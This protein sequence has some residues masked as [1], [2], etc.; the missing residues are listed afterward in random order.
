[1][2]A[3][4]DTLIPVLEPGDLVII[5]S[6]GYPGMARDVAARL[7]DG[8]LVAS[9]PERVNPGGEHAITDIPKLVGGLTPE[10]TARAADVYTPACDVVVCESPEIAEA[11]KLLENTFRAVNLALVHEFDTA[12]RALSIDTH[13][14]IDAAATKPFGFMEFRPG[15]GVGGHCLPVDPFFLTAAAEAAMAG[16]PL[17]HRALRINAARPRVMARRVLDHT[18]GYARIGVLGV[19]YKP[20]VPDTRESPAWEF[21]AVLDGAGCET[22]FHD[23]HVGGS[24]PL[25]TLERWAD[26]IVVHT[27][28]ATVSV[29]EGALWLTREP[30][31]VI[32]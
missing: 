9:S 20:D 30:R 4:V 2:L 13:K 23:P 8:V 6:T 3:A 25:D 24:V 12:M 14:V 28:H 19:T 7:P 16:M 22:R 26:Y 15:A 17:V 10:A 18:G 27:P 5:E 31:R 11:A 32:A 1:V 21:M 29:P